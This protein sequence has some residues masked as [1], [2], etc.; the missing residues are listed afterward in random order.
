M[1]VVTCPYCNEK[2]RVI[3][4]LRTNSARSYF[5]C[6]HCGARSPRAKRNFIE[7]IKTTETV[8]TRDMV[9]KTIALVENDAFDMA[10]RPFD[11]ESFS[12]SDED[13]EEI[14]KVD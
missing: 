6:D 7:D 8:P 9:A 13:L 14:F 12:V 5:I 4:N 1:G 3:T 2:M 10:T 11:I